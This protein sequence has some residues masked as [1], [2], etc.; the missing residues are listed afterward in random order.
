[1]MT[2]HVHDSIMSSAI[3]ITFDAMTSPTWNDRS[4]RADPYGSNSYNPK[5][6]RW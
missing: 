6:K 4:P 3:E 1:M 5:P 2:N